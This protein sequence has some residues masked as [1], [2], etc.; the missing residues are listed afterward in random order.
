MPINAKFVVFFFYHDKCVSV[1]QES[2][3]LVFGVCFS[4]CMDVEFVLIVHSQYSLLPRPEGSQQN[5]V[6]CLGFRCFYLMQLQACVRFM[7]VMHCKQI[8]NAMF[9]EKRERECC[10]CVALPWRTKRS[11]MNGIIIFQVSGLVYKFRST[12]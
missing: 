10:R 9:G 4:F 7:F 5:N 8:H 6:F 2:A 3:S 11:V 12:S 1:Q